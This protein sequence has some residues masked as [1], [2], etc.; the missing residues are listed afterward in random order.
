[1]SNPRLPRPDEVPGDVPA[2]D[3]DSTP[4]QI[5]T[6]QQAPQE[7]T[8][9]SVLNEP[10]AD[11]PTDQI[12]AAQEVHL[13]TT[14]SRENRTA[15]L[16]TGV[17]LALMGL[18]LLRLI[19][20][21]HGKATFALS[22]A[23]VPQAE[24]L[25]D[26]VLPGVPLVVVATV[27]MLAA[28]LAFLF[29]RRLPGWVRG[30]AGAGAATALVIGF[31]TWAAAG[32]PLPFQ[33]SNQLAGTL[34]FATPL[35]FGALAGVLCER[36]GVVNVAIEGQMLT[37]AFTA[38]LVGAVTKSVTAMLVGAVLA[39]VLMAAVLALFTIKYI[40]DQVV[41]GVVI[42]LFAS[43]LT[44]FLFKAIMAPKPQLNEAPLMERIPIPVLSDIPFLGEVL[45][46][47]TWLV[48]LAF[49]SV[50]VVSFLL[51]RTKWGLRVRA[52]G[53][54][55]QAA[56]TVGISVTATR[57]S[58]VLVGGVF[59]GLGGAFFPASTGLFNDD[60]TVGNGFIALAAVIMGRWKPILA[61]C[62]AL[63]FGF[64]QQLGSQVQTL[65][66]PINSQWLILLPYFATIIAVAGLVGRVRAP[67]SDGVPYVKA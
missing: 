31:I 33:V 11:A 5:V 51:Y 46:R 52:V 30:V 55:P 23:L 61:A 27:V 53:E 63:F 9:T 4:P 18:V 35:V 48:Y 12:A 44:A 56:D 21:T 39:G 16:S 26:I 28:A 47:Q 3:R 45:F 10:T 49:V 41:I 40:V 32:R 17:L 2:P 65:G 13:A 62:M 36:S 6:P 64:L 67:A 34:V 24:R 54:H 50:A 66:T 25:P 29:G 7:M 38:T 57:W 42:N 22:D 43:G 60:I 1:M 15:R 59:A 20:A 19:F 14:E 8:V 37:A 58:A